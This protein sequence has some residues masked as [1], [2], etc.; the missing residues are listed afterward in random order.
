MRRYM[1]FSHIRV[2][3]AEGVSSYMF[4]LVTLLALSATLVITSTVAG[5]SRA[6]TIS[7]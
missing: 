1:L 2:T 7:Q 5:N 4:I 6:N 3:T